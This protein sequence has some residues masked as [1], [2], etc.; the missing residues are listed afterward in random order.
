MRRPTSTDEPKTD[1]HT[2]NKAAIIA[3]A[4]PRPITGCIFSAAPDEVGL[5]DVAEVALVVI[6]V[7]V[8]LAVP[9]AVVAALTVPVVVVRVA[10]LSDETTTVEV[11]DCEATEVVLG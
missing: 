1:T 4:K 7:V 9:V 5:A 10:F 11:N 6:A 8:T 2:Y 3:P